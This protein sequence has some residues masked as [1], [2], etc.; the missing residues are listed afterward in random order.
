MAGAGEGKEGTMAEGVVM[1]DA[2]D[3]V[4][5]VDGTDGRFDT[6]AG[7]PVA[8]HTKV[9]SHIQSWR[10]CTGMKGAELRM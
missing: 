2:G 5:Q 9:C 4:G 1:A 10:G 3:G 6:R 7:L 8:C